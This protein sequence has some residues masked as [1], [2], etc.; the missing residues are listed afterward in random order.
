VLVVLLKENKMVK[1]KKV[2]IELFA[3][4]PYIQ[5]YNSAVAGEEFYN[6]YFYIDGCEADA[7]DYARGY[8]NHLEEKL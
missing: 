2:R 7:D 4:A 3:Q 8:E 5:G 1:A 6:P